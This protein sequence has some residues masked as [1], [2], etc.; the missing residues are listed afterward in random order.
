MAGV[1]LPDFFYCFAGSFLASCGWVDAILYALTRRVFLHSDVSSHGA[2]NRTTASGPNARPGDDYGLHTINK[3]VGRT[4]TIVGG[5]SRLGRMVDKKRRYPHDLT[6]HSASGSQD[7][8]IKPIAGTNGITI[9]TETNIQ[10][11]SAPASARDSD[12]L[13]Q[14]KGS[15]GDISKHSQEALR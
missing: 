7:S 1:S 3:D 13:S 15:E 12:D 14:R 2:Y 8:I 9:L 11:E 10:V 4:V 6:E 5:T